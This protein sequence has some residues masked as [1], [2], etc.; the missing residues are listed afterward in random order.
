MEPTNVS[1]EQTPATQSGR[2]D[3]ATT[4]GHIGSI[5]S[6]PGT[7]ASAPLSG[8]IQ[9]GSQRRESARTR[10]GNGSTTEVVDQAKQALTGAYDRT[11]ETVQKTYKQAVDYGRENPMKTMLMVFGAGV[12]AGLLIAN[13]TKSTPRD[14][15]SRIVPSVA[16][17]L[18]DVVSEIF[19]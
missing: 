9:E 16:N 19:R 2:S 6:H 14:R 11:S 15:T 7:A 10:P 3:A 12:G 4:A 17:A 5:P 8:G 13:S 18:A 1:R